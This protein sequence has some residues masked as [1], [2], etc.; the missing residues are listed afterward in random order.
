MRTENT[1]ET[2]MKRALAGVLAGSLAMGAIPAAAFAEAGDALAQNPAEPTAVAEPSQEAAAEATGAA[3]EVATDR[4]AQ[5][6]EV[7]SLNGTWSFTDPDVGE[8]QNVVVPSSWDNYKSAYNLYANIKTCTYE[9]KVSVADYQGKRVQLQFDGVNKI[10][11]V[12]VDGVEV[13]SHTGGFSAF[14]VDITDQCRGKDEVTVT[15]DVTNI[16]FDT[17]PVNSDFTHFAGIYRDVNLVITDPTAQISNSDYGSNGLYL[18]SSVDLSTGTATLSPSVMVDYDLATDAEVELSCELADADGNVVAKGQTSVDVAKGSATAEAIEIPSIELED[19]HLWNGTIDPYLYTATVTLSVDGAAYDSATSRI[20]FRDYEV[21]DGEFYLNGELYELRGVGMHQEYGAETN[22]TTEEQRA[23]DIADVLEMGANALRLCHY[24]HSQYTYDL[25][26]E[27]GIVVWCEAPFYLV[28]LETDLFKQNTEQSVLEMVKQNYNHPS[29]I[30][31]GIQNEVNYYES[32]Q[33]YYPT[34]GSP[35]QLAAF[36]TDLAATVKSTD[37]SRLIGEA[38]INNESMTAETAAWTSGS[39]FN[40]VGFNI[41]TGWYGTIHG[42]T[43]AKKITTF[44]ENDLP[45][46]VDKRIAAYAD[47]SNVSF[48][49]TEYGAGANI[50]QHATVDGSFNWENETTGDFHPE[51]YQSYLHEGSIMALYGDETNG[52]EPLEGLWAA[53]AWSMYDFSCYRNEG[54]TTRLNTK[55][56]VTADRQTKKD[57]FYLYKA[58][59]NDTDL[60]THICS[61]RYTERDASEIEVRVY[62]NCDE[63][64]LLVNGQDYGAGTLSQ[65]GVFVWGKVGLST[66]SNDVVAVG[67]KDGEEVSRDEVTSWVST[68]KQPVYRLYNPTTSEHLWTTDANEYASLRSLG[69]DQEGEAWYSPTTGTGVYRLYNPVLGTHHY[70]SNVTEITKLVGSEGWV[71]D[72]VK[73]GKATPMF[74]SADNSVEG[75]IPVYRLYNDLLSQ[76]HLTASSHENATLGDLGW[77]QEGVGFYVTSK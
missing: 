7:V 32:Y 63:V 23:S 35:E 42:A 17:M 75:S 26:D 16:S 13:G 55:G 9:K 72:K 52:I 27:N 77:S 70:T 74:Y 67:Y 10:A 4:E 49:L 46:N 57:A 73:G 28:Y 6:R 34:Q 15:V 11:K 59:W 69:W 18:S 64:K 8:A 5:T 61:S 24:P 43:K 21:R 12:S 44:V 56:L 53:F 3:D 50:D 76:H 1:R 2:L 19:A 14:Y 22:A 48:V 25:C 33:R 20:G 47:S 39:D 31:W 54:G 40:V 29:I 65:D 60:F 38:T 62:S 37:P 45:H 36:M 66:K 51:E 68:G 30:V 71:F 41:Y 58:N